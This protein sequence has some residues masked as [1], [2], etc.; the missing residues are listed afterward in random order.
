MTTVM[1]GHIEVDDRGLARIAGSRMKVIHLV[2]EKN[3]NGW[4]PEE[5]QQS[6]PQLTLAQVYA[7]LSY[8]HDH[9]P[10][11]DAQIDASV[12]Y[13]EEMRAA[14]PEGPFVKRMR[15]EGKLP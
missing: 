7:A 11:C 12:K 15:A 14:A 8:Y 9:K 2:M 10:E 4:G 3:V 6:F 1:N 5:L 13:A